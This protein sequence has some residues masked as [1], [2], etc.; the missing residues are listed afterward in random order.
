M[1]KIKEMVDETVNIP[2][3]YLSEYPPIPK[4]AKIELTSRCDLKCIYCSLTYKERI[5]VGEI[6]RNFLYKL[7]EELSKIGVKQV[8]LFWL[9]ESLLVKDLPEYV[10]F[11]KKV[12]IKYVFITT[13][14][15]LATPDRI[16]P[17]MESGIDSIKFSINAHN[18]ETYLKLC[19]VDAFDRVISN[20]KSTWNIRGKKEKPA[21]YASSV[22]DP[23]NKGVFEEIGSIIGPYVDQ[24]YPL[25]MY[26]KLTYEE[27]LYG[28]QPTTESKVEP[29]SLKSML[30]CWSLFT[31]PHISYDGY[32]SACYCDHDPRFF[33]GDLKKSP[34]IEAWHSPDLVALRK[35]HLKRDVTG[36]VCENCVAYKH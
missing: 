20:L 18:R 29:R 19:G 5:T 30:P 35:K 2:V 34:F 15:R 31:L 25:R 6:D 28:A 8:G 3:E 1:K 27:Q 22:F 12:G 13:N 4:S 32:L 24:H 16:I 7:L 23:N 17:L 26:G 21:I 36:S 9:G 14:G 33:V 11:A 10:A